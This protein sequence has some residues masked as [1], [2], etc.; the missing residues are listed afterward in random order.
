M[1]ERP[2]VG[3]RLIENPQS[4][5]DKGDPLLDV[6]KTLDKPF[7]ERR[8]P[9]DSN[10]SI[11]GSDILGSP[12]GHRL[13]DCTQPDVEIC[14]ALQRSTEFLFSPCR[15]RQSPDHH[16]EGIRLVNYLNLLSQVG[17]DGVEA[18]SRLKLGI[19]KLCRR[20]HNMC[21]RYN[22]R[23]DG[24]ISRNCRRQGLEQIRVDSV[25]IQHGIIELRYL[26]GSNI[27]ELDRALHRM[28]ICFPHGERLLNHNSARGLRGHCEEVFP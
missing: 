7:L 16:R 3:K 21:H 6:R 23:A 10:F 2:G 13:L 18:H 1:S 17:T 11:W 14:Y 5:I 25:P 15:V 28:K 8:M 24:R 4:S 26:D 22:V 27:H 20:R 19:K 12:L 9:T